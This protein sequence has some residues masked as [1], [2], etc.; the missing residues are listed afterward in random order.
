MIKEGSRLFLAGSLPAGPRVSE[1]AFHAL[2]G[3]GEGDIAVP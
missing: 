1:S 2:I 3:L